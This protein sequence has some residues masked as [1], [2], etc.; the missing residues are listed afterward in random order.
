MKPKNQSLLFPNPTGLS[1]LFVMLL[2][3]VST[4]ISAQL[5]PCDGRLYFTR[6][7]SGPTRTLISAVTV[8]GTSTVGIG[9]VTNIAD[10]QTNA[11]GYYN[12]YIYTQRW[13]VTNFTLLRVDINGNTVSKTVSNMPTGNNYNNAGIDKNGIMYILGTQS[14]D[15]VLYKIDLKNWDAGLTATT[16]N[17][18]MTAG[19]RIWG[20][21]AFDPITGRAYA[22]YH[23]SSTPSSSQ[24]PRGLYEIQNITSSRPSIVKVGG[25]PANYT[26]GSLFFDERGRMFA[27]GVAVDAGTDQKFF[28]NIN[29]SSGQPTQI[30]ESQLSPQSDGCECMYRL[31]LTLT[32]GDNGNGTVDIPACSTPANFNFQFTATN[33]ASGGFSGIT[34]TFPVDPR[35]SFVETA[36]TLKA[37]FDTKFPG[38]NTNVTLSGSNGGTNNRLYVTGINIKGTS[39]NSGNA[40][41][42][43]FGIDV[44]IANAGAINNN[45][46]V[47]FQAT[48]GGLTSYFGQTE[49]SSDPLLFGKQATNL[50]FLRTDNCN[51]SISGSIYNDKDGMANGVNGTAMSNVTVTLYLPDG[52]TQVATTTSN[53]SGAY[54]F[55]N[56]P[57]ASYRVKVTAPAGYAHVSS[58]DAAGSQADG[59]TPVTLGNTNITNVNFGLQQRPSAYSVSL[60][61]Q[62]APTRD[63]AIALTKMPLQGS[64]PEDQKDRSDWIKSNKGGKLKV[65]GLPS[66]DNGNPNGFELSYNN[67]IITAAEIEAGGYLVE[68]YDPSLLVLTPRTV[69]GNVTKTTFKYKTIDSFDAESEAAN[70]VVT[71]AQALP[72]VFG[73]INAVFTE[74]VL[75]VNWQSLSE[76]NNS[77]YEVQV[78]ENGVDFVTIGTVTTKTGGNSSEPVQYHFSKSVHQIT[79]GLAV[80]AMAGG[81]GFRR[82]RGMAGLLVAAGIMMAAVS[83]N[84][85]G[86]DLVEDKQVNLFVRIVQVDTD[87]AKSYSPVVKTIK[88]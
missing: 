46:K 7:M 75:D 55:A 28:Y 30:G 40:V 77:H 3:L 22:W 27:Y 6:Q 11:T 79:L 36:P 84:K 86:N 24:A 32:G 12:G 29:L 31:S 51:K 88:K 80:L 52:S 71:F 73:A 42:T 48:I 16:A 41:L 50:T 20:D 69:T 61:I 62:G 57:A 35:F 44:K 76:E 4:Q 1:N 70:A 14:P 66:G 13:S 25:S 45:E 56:L 19:S 15:P 38:S 8:S 10:V 87:G 74:G 43:N 78:S 49:G 58:T 5:Y 72:V 2:L 82:R 26:M 83:C 23:P 21:I 9:D 63:V 68:N 53:A 34:F 85:Y 37:F 67:H 47:E 81:I 64:D 65:T 18:E 39:E 33:T 59:D 60:H 17:C 54:S